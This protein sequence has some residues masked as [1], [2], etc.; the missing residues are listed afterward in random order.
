M[1]PDTQQKLAEKYAG[2]TVQQEAPSGGGASMQQKLG[3]KYSGY[4]V[5]DDPNG[6]Q[7][8]HS[9]SATEKALKTGN[10][11]SP[12]EEHTFVD[13]LGD[14][15]RATILGPLGDV[16]GAQV[17]SMTND[18]TYRDAL[19]AVRTQ[20]AEKG[21]SATAT[22]VGAV[23]G[24]GMIYKAG[25]S[26]LT[27][28]ATKSGL[29]D[30]AM[31][32]A[33][34]R[35]WYKRMAASAG[36]GG[37]IG[38]AEE[39]IRSNLEEMVDAT[40]GLGFDGGRVAENMM[41][42]AV[43]GAA[44]SPVIDATTAGAGWL[45]NY[46]KRMDPSNPQAAEAATNSILK[47]FK[48]H[49][50]SIEEAGDRFRTEVVDF[51]QKNG[52]MPA[53]IDIV[54]PEQASAIAQVSQAF[55]GLDIRARQL[56][57][58][59]VQR[60]I[61]DLDALVTGGAD[62]PTPRYIHMQMSD[63]FKSTMTRVGSR[64]VEISP[65]K[66]REMQSARPLINQLSASHN[67]AAQRIKNVLDAD[68]N[69][70]LLG[71]KMEGLRNS[72]RSN[73]ETVD[74]TDIQN[75]LANEMIRINEAAK[76]G[77]M[78]VSLLA[79]LRASLQLGKAMKAKREATGKLE[80]T[81]EDIRDLGKLIQQ[82]EEELKNFATNGMKVRL[83][84]INAMRQT[85]SDRFFKL[86]DSAEVDRANE[87]KM[88]RDI[89][90]P[91]GTE[92]KEYKDVIE[93]FKLNMIRA[94]AQDTGALVPKG[95]A[96]I[97][98]LEARLKGG[99]LPKRA[100]VNMDDPKQKYALEEGAAEGT[101]REMGRGLK[102]TPMEG[103]RTAQKVAESKQIQKGMGM[104]LGKEEAKA[105]GKMS[106]NVMNAYEKYSRM[107]A[108]TSKS[109]MEQER[110]FFGDVMTGAVFANLGGAGRAALINRVLTKL[111]IPRG[112]ASQMIEFL[113]RPGAM[114][115]D[116]EELDQ[117]FRMMEKKGIR[118]GPMAAALLA[119]LGQP[120]PNDMSGG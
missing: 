64:L 117:L 52:K 69:I 106:N 7:R 35:N 51:Y 87:A 85:A 97:M 55:T 114:G 99:A 2:A 96:D 59:G 46:Y 29:V 79:E 32:A 14:A 80:L 84:D 25:K 93:F 67:H 98:E 6:V 5:A 33:S 58:E 12:T 39:G 73:E 109:Q 118:L 119:G 71:K 107:A 111:A 83:S 95:T 37:A 88:V 120:V 116:P 38:L 10:F 102:G 105:I 41:V 30:G 70:P 31:K 28:A 94:D 113:G 82:S 47:E 89:I 61:K 36:A 63:L 81:K 13:W 54:A 56:S 42:G 92:V 34:S 1:T 115:A 77:E 22:L 20:R 48:R 100:R 66:M 62:L 27:A 26:L 112:Q 43:F 19:K 60:A 108:P 11:S 4:V 40:A 23:V 65:A 104:S 110:R 9:A 15:G 86:R 24:G 103:V 50:E 8:V 72:L 76:A 57:E 53:A 17:L 101:R 90:T 78:D 68:E 75:Q 21:V 45:R 44:A 16:I 18:V 74:I 49:D 91:I 3:E